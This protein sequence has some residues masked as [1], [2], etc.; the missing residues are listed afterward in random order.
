MFSDALVIP[1]QQDCTYVPNRKDTQT[2]THLH[3]HTHT[4]ALVSFYLK[5]LQQRLMLLPRLPGHHSICCPWRLSGDYMKAAAKFYS[6]SLSSFSLSLFI[7]L[8]LL[9]PYVLHHVTL[10]YICTHTHTPLS[11]VQQ[12]RLHHPR[13]FFSGSVL[14][15]WCAGM[16]TAGTEDTHTHT[17]THIYIT[18]FHTR[19]VNEISY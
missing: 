17:H 4:H 10:L 8:F 19:T 7:P 5:L 13:D 11:Q 14:L 12:W 6:D 2:H 9:N 16:R 3:L 1:Q 18:L 15:Q